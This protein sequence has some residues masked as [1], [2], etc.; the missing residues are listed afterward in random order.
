MPV[1]TFRGEGG[2]GLAQDAVLGRML[3]HD[4]CLSVVDQVTL[5]VSACR[6][7]AVSTSVT[8]TD[9]PLIDH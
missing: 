7:A 4:I 9:P 8:C 5:V 3:A 6:H 1:A 2:E